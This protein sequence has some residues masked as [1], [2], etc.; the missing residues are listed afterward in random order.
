MAGESG[1]D[2]DWELRSW[3]ARRVGRDQR[4]LMPADGRASPPA[5]ASAAGPPLGAGVPE[6]PV[7]A[8]G[9]GASAH[10]DAAQRG[11]AAPTPGLR[12]ATAPVRCG[13]PTAVTFWI[14]ASAGLVLVAA[15]A[16]AALGATSLDI[17]IGLI[18]ASVV[19]LTF[20]SVAAVALAR[21]AASGRTPGGL[22]VALPGFVLG[23]A[24]L[25]LVVFDVALVVALGTLVGGGGG[26]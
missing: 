24:G 5:R 16:A 18:A 9:R 12:A 3:P 11:P 21:R 4:P 1:L 17:G 25:A 10:I 23:W 15:A 14:A 20:G 2:I 26:A 6:T 19:A 22:G 8:C 7:W 13:L